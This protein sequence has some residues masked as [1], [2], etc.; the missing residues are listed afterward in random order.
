MVPVEDA[1]GEAQSEL[2]GHAAKATARISALADAESKLAAASTKLDT[3][4]AVAMEV[5]QVRYRKLQ[6]AVL[7]RK[8]AVEEEANA[9]FAAAKA[10][11]DG[12]LAAIEDD[13]RHIEH[14]AAALQR[15][16]DHGQPAELLLASIGANPGLL[17]QTGSVLQHPAHQHQLVRSPQSDAQQCTM[18]GCKR[19]GGVSAWQC[20]AGCSWALCSLC[21]KS[22]ELQLTPQ[23]PQ[24]VAYV[25]QDPDLDAILHGIDAVVASAM[26]PSL[27]TLA[28]DGASKLE[29][30]RGGG[31][32]AA[33]FVIATFSADGSP[34]TEGGARI[35]AEVQLPTGATVA[36]AVHDPGD[37]TYTCQYAI[38]G[39]CRHA[40]D[41]L[42]AE[43]HVRVNG[44]PVSKSPFAVNIPPA[45]ERKT[46]G[47]WL[48]K[49]QHAVLPRRRARKR[50]LAFMFVRG[51]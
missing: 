35:E 36:V 46:F 17:V 44:E 50:L 5:I 1:V 47:K 14:A 41:G 49:M 10:G 42:V 30:P 26:D 4:H 18:A 31:A 9:K 29:W 8:S 32:G 7:A 39:A 45:E 43:L 11:L 28:G 20:G 34:A 13:R 23:Y 37:G 21:A 12:Q 33:T 25:Q 51:V 19:S 3:S 2:Q 15:T 6:R 24:A 27:S 40:T 22:H 48:A 16:L 38:E